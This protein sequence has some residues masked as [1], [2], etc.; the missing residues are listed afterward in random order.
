MD[1]EEEITQS[2]DLTPEGLNNYQ[3]DFDTDPRK[4][5]RATIEQTDD[6][7]EALDV[8]ENELR[9]EMDMRAVDDPDLSDDDMREEIEDADIS[10]IDRM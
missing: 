8:P 10:E 4:L 9:E 6:P 2:N 5:D 7:V 1:D 3:D